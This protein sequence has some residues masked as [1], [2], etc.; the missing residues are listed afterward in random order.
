M[1]AALVLAIAADTIRVAD[2]AALRRA[3]AGAPAGRVIVVSG[4]RYTG[5]LVLERRVALV[6]EGRPAIRG[7]GAGSVLRIRAAGVRVAGLM[8]ERSGA[9]L[10]G[11]DAGVAV[12]ADSV[13]LEDLTLM[14]VLHGVYLRRA[15]HAVLRDLV[16]RGRAAQRPND[17]GDGVHLYNASH[18]TV[19]GNDIADVRDGMYFSYTDST[20]VLGN[21]VTRSRYGLHYMFSHVNRF[22]RNRF[23]RSSAGS[24]IMNSRDVTARDNVFA[25]N[26]GVGSFGLLLQT[27]ER[28][29]LERN[30]FVGNGVGLFLDGAVDGLV[31][32]NLVADNFVGLELFPSATGNRI[33]GNAIVGNTYAATGSAG[34]TR[35]CVEGRGN[36]W[37]G[38]DGW[39]LDGDGVHDVAYSPVSPL[40]EVS[41]ERPALRLWLGSPAAA[42]LGWAERALPVFQVNA[43]TDDCPLARAAPLAPGAEP[44]APPSPGA[45][46]A[47]WLAAGVTL[48][49]G[50]VLPSLAGERAA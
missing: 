40:S 22:E 15:R 18:A 44:P 38:D 49:A 35:L 5:P 26:R 34:D 48:A 29:V 20:V 3:L 6:G 12:E 25:F 36:Y 14:D 42:A 46:W 1:L 8:L 30:R 16:I 19:I 11:D 27:T 47:M 10:A 24:S 2:D 13:T 45:R 7:G 21:R 17:R 39:D 43:V 9:D 23:T 37:S 50:A 28:A 32:D 33:T 31:R 4:G 41:R